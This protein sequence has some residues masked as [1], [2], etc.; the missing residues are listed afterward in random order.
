MGQKKGADFFVELN[1]KPFNEF[2]S[3]Y[4]TAVTEYMAMIAKVGLEH[5]RGEEASKN[6]LYKMRQKTIDIEKYGK[7]FRER[8]VLMEKAE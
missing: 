2:I 6:H 5:E 1:K 3:D 8:T 7:Q 4:A